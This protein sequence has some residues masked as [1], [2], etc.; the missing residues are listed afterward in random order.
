ML[1]SRRRSK[2][3]VGLSGGVDSSLAAAVLKE[4]GFFVI[5]VYMKNWSE[6][7]LGVEDCPWLRDQ[8]DARMV[9][10]QLDIPF[11]TVNFEAEYKARVL[12]PF[13]AEY[14]RGR[15]PNPDILCNQHIK[16]DAFWRYA[17]ALGAEMIA[18]GHY[19]RITRGKLHK[20]SDAKKDQSYFLWAIRP[21]VL[22]RVI[23][24]LGG[25][26]KTQV[27]LM[28]KQR[29]LITANKKDSQGICFVGPADVGDFLARRLSGR[30]GPVVNEAGEVIGRHRGAIFYTLGQRAGI[31]DISWPDMGHRPTLYV[32]A[33]DVAANRVVVGEEASLY[34]RQLT[35]N[36]VSWLSPPPPIGRPLKAKIRYG[37]SDAACVMLANNGDSIA[38]EFDEPQRAV[39]PGQSVVLYVGTRVVGGGVIE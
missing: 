16:F 4:K 37:Q 32:L 8:L 20:G 29:G 24:P 19:A 6:P 18:T 11:Y 36:Q 17:Q 14:A 15:T 10:S 35:A 12:E 34:R 39:T 33:T 7:I 3:V 30:D 28:A 2:I 26:N 21:E 22:P 5:G 38:L 23:F 9:A 13:L 1:L 31:G 27:R 25:L